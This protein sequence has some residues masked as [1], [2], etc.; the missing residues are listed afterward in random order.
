MNR[1]WQERPRPARLECRY[2]FDSYEQL[3]DFLDRAA[4]MD[5]DAVDLGDGGIGSGVAFADRCE[6]G[7]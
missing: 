1:P 2:E 6:S 4:E 5:L 3:R 7:E